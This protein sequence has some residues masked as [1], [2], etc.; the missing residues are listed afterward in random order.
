MPGAT[1]QELITH[2]GL[3]TPE[4]KRKEKL[5]ALLECLNREFFN[6]TN[7]NPYQLTGLLTTEIFDNEDIQV[8]KN[9]VE[10]YIINELK[11]D[12]EEIKI[13][14]NSLDF[15]NNFETKKDLKATL[16]QEGLEIVAGSEITLGMKAWDQETTLNKLQ[17]SLPKGK[18]LTQTKYNKQLNYETPIEINLDFVAISVKGKYQSTKQ[19]LE[20]AKR[21]N[22]RPATHAEYLQY[23][24]N[25]E[26]KTLGKSYISTLETTRTSSLDA[27]V[28]YACFDESEFLLVAFDAGRGWCD[29]GA[30]LF[31]R[32]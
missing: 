15:R 13:A 31:V 16:E 3:K 19:I 26:N 1:Q 8:L 21:D 11:E 7:I 24:I 10:E 2:L 6:T 4:Q 18:T 17:T 32:K 20:T 28:P 25:S 22:L 23:L 5:D 14:L 9:K 30:V 29:D 27:L 12:L